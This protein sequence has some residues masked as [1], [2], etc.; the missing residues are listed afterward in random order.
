MDKKHARCAKAPV[1][2]IKEMGKSALIATKRNYY[3]ALSELNEEKEYGC[4]GAGIC[5]G[6]H[7]MHE[8]KVLCFEEVMASEDHQE[9]GNQCN[10]NMIR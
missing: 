2:L 4:V 10:M 8:L 3:F 5:L 7:N 6:I 9:W 1:Q